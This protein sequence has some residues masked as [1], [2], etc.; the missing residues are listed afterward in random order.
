MGQYGARWP[1]LSV[2]WRTFRAGQGRAGSV[3][4]AAAVRLAAT[5]LGMAV[6]AAVGGIGVGAGW[7]PGPGAAAVWEAFHG[8][9]LHRQQVGG[10]A[11]LGP[12]RMRWA[13]TSSASFC[14]SALMAAY[15]GANAEAR[16]PALSA[17]TWAIWA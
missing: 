13:N 3:P 9:A 17:C 11:H 15:S 14:C 16:R 7:R 12:G 1:A 2:R 8:V 10:A 6:V 5:R 4:A